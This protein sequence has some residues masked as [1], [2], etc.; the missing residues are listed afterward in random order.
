M[1]RTSSGIFATIAQYL[2][3]DRGI[4]LIETLT[5][6][7]IAG[8]VT[9]AFL[10]AMQTTSIATLVHQDRVIAESLGKSQLECIRSQSYDSI[11]NPPQYQKLA[12]GDIPTGYDLIITPQRLDPKTDG[13]ANDDGLQKITVAVTHGG[14]TILIFEDY[15]M[16]R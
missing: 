11:N 2:K 12:A 7:A 14:T 8:I 16:N 5:A 13:T 4:S 9:V 3:D 6:L 1:S 15:K 10:G